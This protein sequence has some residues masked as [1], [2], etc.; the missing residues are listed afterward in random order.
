MWPDR[1]SNPGP[2]AMWHP[3]LLQGSKYFLEARMD[4]TYNFLEAKMDAT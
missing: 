4:A 1:V 3:A 2:S